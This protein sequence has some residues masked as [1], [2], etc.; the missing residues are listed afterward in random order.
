[1]ISKKQAEK[2]KTKIMREVINMFLEEDMP[3]TE[4]RGNN[5]YHFHLGTADCANK[6][7]KTVNTIISEDIT[8]DEP[9]AP[10]NAALLSA[11]CARE[12][13]QFIIELEEFKGTSRLDYESN[14]NYAIGVA[15]MLDKAIE[16]I[17]SGIPELSD[18]K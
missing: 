2:I 11:L 9:I 12:A 3:E 17:A 1:M 6:F 5:L 18:V 16:I 7:C 15:N 13:M 4:E 14:L 8:N 10:Y